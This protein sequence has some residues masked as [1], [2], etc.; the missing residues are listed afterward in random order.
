MR[1]PTPPLGLLLC[2]ELPETSA[3][4]LKDQTTTAPVGL[5]EHHRPLLGSQGLLGASTQTKQLSSLT[6]RP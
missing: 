6:L 1:S 5:P 3:V 4:G 2:Q